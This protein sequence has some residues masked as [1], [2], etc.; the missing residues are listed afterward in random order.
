MD[1]RPVIR[2]EA[3]RYGS[4]ISLVVLAIGGAHL[5]D[6][7]LTGA[8][9]AMVFLLCVLVTAA[10][11]GIGPALVAALLAAFSYNF[12]FL[13]P[14]HTF[15]ISRPGDVLTFLVFFAVALA[16][17]W[18]GGR[19]RDNARRSA[20]Q[21]AATSTLLEASRAL[22]RAGSADDAAQALAE[23]LAS[24][25][26]APAVVLLP[27]EGGLR[28]AGAP[29]GLTT[30]APESLAAA[31]AVWS[32]EPARPLSSPAPRE[33]ERAGSEWTFALL[34]GVA[35][36]VGVVGLRAGHPADPDLAPALI[37]QG[38]VVIERAALASAAGENEVLRQADQLRAGLLNSIS[39]DFRT[40]LASILGSAT[41]LSEYEQQLAPGVRRDLLRSIQE[42]AERLNEHVGALLDM[43][44][45]EGGAL[46]PREEW[47]DVRELI[48]SAIR[49]LATRLGGHRIE[50]DFA[51]RLSLVKADPTLVEQAILNLLDNAAVHTP[52]GG[53]LRVSAHEDARC[54]VVSVDDEGPGVPAE[55]QAAIFDKFRR[56]PS[57]RTGGLGL[58]LSITKGFIEAMGGRVA[59]ASPL[60][61]AGGSRFM[62]GLNKVA[63][64][65]R[66]LL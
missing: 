60:G 40:P 37:E 13:E 8:D 18:L 28:L 34:T 16:T 42:D 27:G 36:P 57:D 12:F 62:I 32:R 19:A 59:L 51:D 23:H 15:R 63:E 38:G 29:Q 52:P 49:R 64:T 41:T 5:A 24:A 33:A 53:T 2:R 48:G 58:G 55:Q 66:G 3:L 47:V 6:Q 9:L 7:A 39:H 14:L 17:G 1:P 65:P 50:R 22:A 4:A 61:P 20:V 26:G 45:L 54:V 25:T 21:A 30:L 43:G 10:G 56:G 44:R 35:G 11:V 31:A 46:K